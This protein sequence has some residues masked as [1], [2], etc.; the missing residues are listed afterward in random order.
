MTIREKKHFLSGY[1]R[2]QNAIEG[3]LE[4][5]E[6]WMTIGT[7]VNQT[8]SFAT[9]AGGDTKSKVERAAVE[10][11]TIIE[12]ISEDIARAEEQKKA[13]ICAIN[14]KCRYQR[15]REMLLYRYVKRLSDAR[16]AVIL[17]K[18]VKTVQRCINQAI[19]DIDL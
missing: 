16:I 17:G 11:Q 3:D 7:K 13:V 14:A 9:V 19:R 2:A 18:D 6:R 1:I 15:Q 4:E 8:Y 12:G 5:M 10:I